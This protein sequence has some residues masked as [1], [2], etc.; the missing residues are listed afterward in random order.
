MSS[1]HPVHYCKNSECKNTLMFRSCKFS[2]SN[3][4][5]KA[6][7]FDVCFSFFFLSS[8]YQLNKVATDGLLVKFIAC[9]EQQLIAVIK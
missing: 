2:I 1:L 6:L 7:N 9:M 8:F 4:F 3:T 5:S